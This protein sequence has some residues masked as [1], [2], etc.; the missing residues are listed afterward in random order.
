MLTRKVAIIFVISFLQELGPIMQSLFGMG[1]C[2]SGGSA[3]QQRRLEAIGVGNIA[4]VCSRVLTQFS[5]RLS[6]AADLIAFTLQVIY[7]PFASDLLDHLEALGLF[8]AVVTLYLGMFL[9]TNEES[10]AAGEQSTWAFVVS[11]CIVVLNA[12]TMSCFVFF[13]VTAL[14]REMAHKVCRRG[15]EMP[16]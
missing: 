5:C 4:G 8:T 7:S 13:M 9:M 15:A 11:L 3:A 6:T 1:V 14:W 16:T 12:A 2:A 10:I